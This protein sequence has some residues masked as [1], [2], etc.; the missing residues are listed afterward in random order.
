MPLVAL[1]APEM[2]RGLS[3]SKWVLSVYIVI[4]DHF[5]IHVSRKSKKYVG[6]CP[7][8]CMKNLDHLIPRR[9]AIPSS[10]PGMGKDALYLLRKFTGESP[11][12][13]VLPADEHWLVTLEGFDHA[14]GM[15]VAE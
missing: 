2:Y 8:P 9:H 11:L 12:H 4:V 3:L 6:N 15:G 10:M 1:E 5:G 13:H 7:G 14:A